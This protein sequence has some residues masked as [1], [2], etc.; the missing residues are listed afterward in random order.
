MENEERGSGFYAEASYAFSKPLSAVF[1]V[2]VT[3]TFK[4]ILDIRERTTDVFLG[5]R[6]QI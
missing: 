4:T 1:R 6:A 5:L 2:D 3:R